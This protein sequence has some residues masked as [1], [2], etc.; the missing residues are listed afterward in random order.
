MSVRRFRT[1][2]LAEKNASALTV[3]GYEVDLEQFAA[4]RWGVDARPPFDWAAVTPDDAKA[5]LM[6][7][8]REKAFATTTRRKVACLR[9]FFRFLV[10]DGRVADNP[11]ARLRGPKLPKPLPKVFSKD[12]VR[13]FLEAPVFDLARRRAAGLA[14]SQHE[15]YACLRDA[16]LFEMLYSTGCRISEVIALSWR[17]IRFDN[18]SVIVSGKGGK[19]RLCILGKP[20]CKA[21]Q[22]L[23]AAAE[24]LFPDGGADAANVFLNERGLAFTPR[25]AQRRMKRWLAAADLPHDLTPHKLR[26]SFATHLLDAGADLRSVQEM[27]GHSSLATTQIYTHVSVERLKDEYMKAHPRAR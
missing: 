17:Q 24:G 11:F 23:R 15:E 16:A 18:G 22:T 19:Q 13:R 2:L 27:L 14:V 26:H 21:L 3:T 9:T 10:R 6:A 1:Y 20:A 8:A 12:E 5:F 7:F 4:F 25:E